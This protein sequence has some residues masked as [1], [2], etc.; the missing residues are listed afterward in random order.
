[1]VV[2]FDLDKSIWLPHQNRNRMVNL[3]WILISINHFYL[4]V[5]AELK[6]SKYAISLG[7][8]ATCVI[9]FRIYRAISSPFIEIQPAW[10]I[11]IAFLFLWTI[12]ISRY[13]NPMRPVEPK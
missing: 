7:Q 4:S 13:R 8:N 10:S 9:E 6:R 3:R 2:N 12:L 1:M 11:G 5:K